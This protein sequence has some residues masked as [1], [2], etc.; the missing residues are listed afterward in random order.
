MERIEL[1]VDAHS[2]CGVKRQT[3]QDCMGVNNWISNQEAI[4]QFADSDYS[5]RDNQLF[6]VADGIGGHEDGEV[7]SRFAVERLYEEFLKESNFQVHPAIATIHS[8]LTIKGGHSA[9][10]MGTTIVGLI[11]TDYEAI[12]FSVGD[13]SGYIIRNNSIEQATHTDR[14]SQLNQNIISS[15]LGGGLPLPNPNIWKQK[16]EFGDTLLLISDGIS[17]WVSDN[18]IRNIVQSDHENL[19]E[20]LCLQAIRAGGGDDVSAIVIKCNAR[21]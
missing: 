13:S 8:E 2:K 21:L 5:G 12:F 3:N 7:A 4:N 16:L 1:I 17:N 6:L 10:P 14:P 19:S 15:C 9:K 20:L 18:Q 11:L